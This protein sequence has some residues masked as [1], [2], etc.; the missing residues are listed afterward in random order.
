LTW[1]VAG[2]RVDLA[3]FETRAPAGTDRAATEAATEALG[4]E[5]DDLQERLWAEGRRS[6]LVVLQAMDAGGKDGTIRK[7]F[8][9]LNPQGVRVTSF[10]APTEEELARDFLWRVHRHVPRAGEIGIFNRSH[11]EDVLV[12]RVQEL[13]GEQVWRGRYRQIRDFEHL[14]AA[15]GTDIVK[16]YLHISREEQADRFA[17]RREEKPWKWDDADLTARDRWDDYRAAYEEA[18]AETAADE[19]P[20]YVVPADQ[21]WYRNWVVRTILA[22][23][24]RATD[25]QPRRG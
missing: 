17:K 20:W 7:V 19:A 3:S 25:P 10:A 23:R 22:E 9:G 21:K 15:D 24:L 11:Y 12:V 8:T 4:D 5:L 18:I 6:L 14:L 13:V 2:A 16:L 1:R